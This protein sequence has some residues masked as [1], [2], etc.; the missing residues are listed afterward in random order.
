MEITDENLNQNKFYGDNCLGGWN[1]VYPFG[2][3][4]KLN[5]L[6]NG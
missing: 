4:E 2:S 6:E 1:H 3:Q 5:E